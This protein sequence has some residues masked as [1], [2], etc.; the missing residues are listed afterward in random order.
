MTVSLRFVQR[1][2]AAVI[3]CFI[4]ATAYISVVIG[5]RQNAVDKVSRYNAAWTVGQALAEFLRLDAAL[6]A[7]SLPIKASSFDEVKLRLDILFSRVATLEAAPAGGLT[8]LRS[9]RRFA[10]SEP[11]IAESIAMLRSRLEAIDKMIEADGAN[12]DVRRALEI[13]EPLGKEMTELSARAQAYGAA[14]AEEDQEELRRLHIISTTLAAGLILCGILLTFLLLRQN[15]LLATAHA[16]L[17]SASR[18]LEQTHVHLAAQNGRFTAALNNMSQALCTCDANGDLVVFNE[19][20]ARLFG[21]SR[22]EPGVKL[23]EA[24][25]A[26]SL[27]GEPSVLEPLH[28][29]QMPFV[30]DG[31]KGDFTLDLPGGRSFAVAH[32]P[33]AEGGW[34]AT[35]EDVSDRRQAE[36]HILYMAQH[37]AL[38][39]LPN[40]ALLRKWLEARCRREGASHGHVSIFLLDLDGFK[41]VNDTLGHHIGDE[42]LKVVARRL[43]ACVLD[44]DCVARLGGDEFAVLMP[45]GSTSADCEELATRVL[46]SLSRTFLV[47]GH[48]ITLS[49]SIGIAR[50]PRSVSLT[51]SVLLKQA[52]VAMYRGKA[53]GKARI[54]QFTPDMEARLH[55]RRAMEA[56]L[57][58]AMGRGELEVH[59]QPLLG[60]DTLEIAGYEA[61]LRWNRGGKGYVSP[62]EFIP[63]A[64]DVG[65]IDTLGE[66]V[67][68]E[69]CREARTWPAGIFVSVNLSP[70]QFRES[71]L[72]A[73]VREVL[74]STQLP[75]RSLELEITESVV[76]EANETTLSTLHQLRE[77]GV[78]IV[79]DDFGPGYSSLSYLTRFPFDKIKI[80]RS[81]VRDVPAR[82]DA[83]AIVRLIVQL[84]GELGTTTTAEG[85]ETDEQL[86]RLREIGCTQVQGF[87]FAPA[88]P[89]G[90]IDIAKLA[91][92]KSAS[93]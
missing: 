53:E 21:R 71:D 17:S 26:R 5:E 80:D 49:A 9:L 45:E 27:A 13:A 24:L 35:Y 8:D 46:E 48:K 82:R 62:G 22:L 60:T 87:L 63:L 39:D 77:W 47:E 70:L 54:V 69:A 65:L 12:F 40:R 3:C 57:R 67:L 14:R 6:A 29:H 36:A 91:P 88:R 15:R 72:A 50:Q 18:E 2:L 30:R 79:L 75:P 92:L 61:L 84:A 52:D 74:R 85:V 42:V 31:R 43:R 64:E 73:K 11:K 58:E 25:A 10:I 93:A 81:F 55:A 7:Y 90:Q 34:L 51:P 16:D 41:E 86:A 68:G 33:L 83:R 76:M 56:D 59:Y 89:A 44:H 66:W 20:F 32:E 23:E 78:R 4:V 28:R 37:D 1:A 38:T 19:Q